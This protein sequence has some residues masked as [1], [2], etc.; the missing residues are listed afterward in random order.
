MISWN[1]TL[2]IAVMLSISN[3]TYGG[4]KSWKK[5]CITERGDTVKVTDSIRLIPGKLAVTQEYVSPHF[6]YDDNKWFA[7]RDYLSFMVGKTYPIS[8]LSRM[9][10]EKEP[11]IYKP[12]VIVTQRYSKNSTD[13]EYI[14]LLD[15]ALNAGVV[16]VVKG[17]K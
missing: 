11:D 2:L 4:D 8:R 10:S 5:Y 17:P 6:R 12:V 13:V 15:K 1:N 3:I 9:D 7:Y 14:I 16:E